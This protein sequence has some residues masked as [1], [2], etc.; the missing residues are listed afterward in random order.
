MLKLHKT[1]RRFIQKDMRKRNPIT[2]LL[3]KPQAS[4]LS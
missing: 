2:R 4:F 1:R 3:G